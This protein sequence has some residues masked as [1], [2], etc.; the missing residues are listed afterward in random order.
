[1]FGSARSTLSGNTAKSELLLGAGTLFL[2]H[3]RIPIQR[4]MA[5][6]LKWKAKK[7]SKFCLRWTCIWQRSTNHPPTKNLCY[8][9]KA[10][11]K[12]CLHGKDL[13]F[14]LV[15]SKLVGTV[16][17]HPVYFTEN[18]FTYKWCHSS[19]FLRPPNSK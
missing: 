13:V 11:K 6:T 18:Y 4:Q 17:L 14:W 5:L 15:Q 19:S 1:M 7:S 12:L 3:N 9:N 10:R 8:R 2:Q 16:T